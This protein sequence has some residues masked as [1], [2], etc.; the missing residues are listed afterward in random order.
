VEAGGSVPLADS[1]PSYFPIGHPVRIKEDV[2]SA[3][4][5]RDGWVRSVDENGR[6][7]YVRVGVADHLWFAIEEVEG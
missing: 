5:G 2:D 7:Y 4:A 3:F 6:G 1:N